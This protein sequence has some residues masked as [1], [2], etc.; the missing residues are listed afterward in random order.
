MTDPRHTPD[1]TDKPA[2]RDERGVKTA[3]RSA[4]ARGE[5]GTDADF[6]AGDAGSAT[7]RTD[8]GGIP[9]TADAALSP[10]MSGSSDI[11]SDGPSVDRRRPTPPDEGGKPSSNQP[12]PRKPGTPPPKEAD[13][14][15]L[16]ESMGKAVSA[17]VLGA[18]D[19]DP[20]EPAK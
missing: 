7:N 16:L 6:L 19:E 1:T 18:A 13:D 15:N 10:S 9:S 5:T 12:A 11:T 20:E 3:G 17:P 8:T 14:D 4:D 2:A